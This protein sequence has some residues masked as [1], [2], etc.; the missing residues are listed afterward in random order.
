MDYPIEK[1]KDYKFPARTEGVKIQTQ[2]EG[3]SGFP[4]RVNNQLI[5]TSDLVSGV[6]VTDELPVEGQEGVLYY[7]SVDGTLWVWDDGSYHPI[8]GSTDSKFRGIY[9][10]PAELS[11]I[12]DPLEGDYATVV[13]TQT[14]WSYDGTTWIDTEISVL[15]VQSVNG[16]T[17]VVVLDK[18][19]IGLENVDNTS[20]LNKPVSTA[21]QSSIDQLDSE[22]TTE[23]GTLNDRVN[24]AWNAIG[25]IDYVDNVPELKKHKIGEFHDYTQSPKDVNE[26]ITPLVDNGDG[27]YTY[28]DQTG[29]STTFSANASTPPEVS[30]EQTTYDEMG[31]GVATT[32]ATL[33]PGLTTSPQNYILNIY[34][35]GLLQRQG[36]GKDCETTITNGSVEVTFPAAPKTN[37]NIVIEANVTK[38]I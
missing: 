32:F 7:N 10:T 36:S 26:T 34:K 37:D 31:N 11:S 25:N 16:K 33:V 22:V 35:N 6:V 17:G 9:E 8:G 2:S 12:E 4:S 19:D 1:L 21:T 23:I 5:G 15:S 30:V 27:T 24:D 13:E 28:T 29:V 20:D 18:T 14:T 38:I 3:K